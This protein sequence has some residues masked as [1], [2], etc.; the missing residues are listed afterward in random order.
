MKWYFV[1]DA[2]FPNRRCKTDVG[3]IYG[4]REWHEL[5][6]C[7]TQASRSDSWMNFWMNIFKSLQKIRK[8]KPIKENARNKDN[9]RN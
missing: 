1:G 3:N 7:S 6:D 5:L 4:N 2:E 8:L 9:A